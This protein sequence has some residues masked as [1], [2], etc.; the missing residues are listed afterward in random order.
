M[1]TKQLHRWSIRFA[2]LWV[3]LAPA[4]A[5][6]EEMSWRQVSYLT[7]ADMKP[8]GD[9]EGHTTATWGRRGLAFL[10]GGPADGEVAVCV[11]AGTQENTKEKG[12]AIGETTFTFEDGSSFV[13][14]TVTEFKMPSLKSPRRL[15]VELSKGTG[16]FDGIQGKGSGTGKQLT[17]YGDDSK[18][19]AYFDVVVHYTLPKQR[20]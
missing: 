4:V 20:T 16:R 3:S 18:S 8:V 9:V 6:G 11:S 5:S 14:R 19:E 17:P 7:K 10:K 13:V 1:N 2:L 15:T 12:T